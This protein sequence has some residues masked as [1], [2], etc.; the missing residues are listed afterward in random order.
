[1]EYFKYRFKCQK[2]PTKHTIHS[3]VTYF[4]GD[5]KNSVNYKAYSENKNVVI[6]SDYSFDWDS[7][8]DFSI[9]LK[10]QNGNS[11]VCKIIE[12]IVIKNKIEH[13]EGSDVYLH[14]IISYS[15]NSNIGKKKICPVYNGA[16]NPNYLFKFKNELEKNLGVAISKLDNKNFERGE[17][18]I[19]SNHVQINDIIRFSLKAKVIDKELFSSLKY[20]AIF[21]R[22]SYG[23]GNITIL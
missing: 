1:M 12:K 20:R 23:M 16:I 15:V 13:E 8:C 4:L 19:I 22:K 14:G 5:K 7:I 18:E 6:V 11:F 21:R 10:T 3:L 2:E 17:N 9:T